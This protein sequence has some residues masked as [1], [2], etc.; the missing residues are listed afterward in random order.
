[1]EEKYSNYTVKDLNEPMSPIE[2]FAKKV[3]N[4]LIEEG[5]PPIPSNYTLYFFNML[6]DEPKEFKD[7][8]Y[9]I[10]SIEEANDIEKDLELE[11]KLKISFKYSKEILQRTALLYKLT[12]QLRELLNDT[13]KQLAHLASPKIAEKYLKNIENK[14]SKIS[15][16]MNKEL[17]EI[18][19]TYS[20]NVEIIK[21]IESNSMFDMVYGVYNAK[22]FKK[23]VENEIKLI[24]KFNHKSS[25][26]ALKINENILKNLK[27]EKSLVILNRSIA[28]ILLKTSRRSDIVAHLGDGVFAMLLKHTDTFGA[29]K[30]VERLSDIIANSAVFIEGEEIEIKIVASICEIEGEKTADE[31]IEKCIELLKKAQKENKLYV[32]GD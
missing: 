28:K 6:E 9:E 2:K 10:L 27:R 7:Q 1:M 13:L 22:Y 21:E 20:K 29:K 16:T 3:F 26:V 11:K 5:V 19:E 30:T 25:L 31:I 12:K 24:K 18:K 17:K 14:I 8:V 32:E 15:S 23:M 4:K